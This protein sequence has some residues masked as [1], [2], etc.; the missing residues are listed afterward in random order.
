[1]AT[2]RKRTSANGDTSYHVQVRLKGHPTETA[3]FKRKTDTDKWAQQTG[4][5]RFIP[6]P[7]CILQKYYCNPNAQIQ[8]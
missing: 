7:L 1:M 4:A 8:F 2:I 6:A 3:S 5:A